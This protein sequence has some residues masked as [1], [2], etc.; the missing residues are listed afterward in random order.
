MRTWLIIGALALLGICACVVLSRCGGLDLGNLGI[1]LSTEPAGILETAPT[2]IPAATAEPFVAPTRPA[3]SKGQT[4]LVMLYEDA[5][6]KIL[7]QDIYVDLNEAERVG[8]SDSVKIV[9]QMDRFSAGYTG[10]GNWTSTRRY[11]V[12]QD[13]DLQSVGSQLVQDLGEANMSDPNTLV[14][15]VAWAVQTFPADKQVLILSDHGMGWP[16]GMSD[17]APAARAESSAP[18]ASAIGNLM[19]LNNLDA[20]LQTIREQTGLDKLEMIGLDACLMGQVEVLDMLAP[21]ARYAVVSEETE[22][23]LGWAYT[24]FLQALEQ[25]PGMSGAELGKLIVDS[26]VVDD[27]R[28]VDDQARADLLR[29]GSPMGG[30]FGVGSIPSAS[31]VATEMG[32]DITLT[33]VDLS[34]VPTL[35]NGVNDLSYAL[36]QASQ[37][38]VARARTYAQSFTSIFGQEVPASYIDLGNFVQL[39]KQTGAGVNGAADSVLASIQ[40]AVVA[41]KHG[42]GKP[43]ATGISIYFPNSQL[44]QSPMAGPESYTAIASRFAEDSTWDDF[45]TF[46]YTGQSF[47]AAAHQATVPPSGTTVTAPGA[48]K[49]ELTPIQLSD[50]TAA[51]GR[52]VTLSTDVSSQNL[53]YVFLFA[54]YYDQQ[55]NSIFLADMDYLESSDTRQIDG[56]YYPVWPQV[57]FTME[58]DWEPLVFEI[59]DGT[60]SVT[61]L[62][63]PVTYGAT[64]EEAVY[65]VDGTYTFASGESRT[66]RLYFSNGQL[67]QVFGFNGDSTAGSPAEI[68]PQ[69]GDTFTV[70][71]SWLDLDSQGKVVQRATQ[72]GG[73]LTFGDQMFSWKELDAAAGDYLVGF[74]AEDLDGNRTEVYARVTVE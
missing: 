9:A 12:T 72:Q 61:A 25:D 29:Q 20:A 55:S 15:F 32:H 22:P 50:P 56:V 18:L 26:Y 54:G 34:A 3:G 17:P 44:F 46:H 69:T 30:L 64:P 13:N 71:E 40:K 37:S 60:D 4:W 65:A 6:D 35:M 16:G 70:L 24:G 28:I 68:Y 19:Y 38:E 66:A 57:G 14:D 8:S 48:G 51:P 7:E 52:P 33:A 59:S 73:T 41:E 53:G 43:G 11:Y 42:S 62:L 23:A 27:Q 2:A 39:L 47:Q 63:T 31:Q 45:L 1:S 5:D 58:F 67:R 74:I 10:D 21:H 36:Q 49:I